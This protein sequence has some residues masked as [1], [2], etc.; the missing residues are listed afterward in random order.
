MHAVS[1]QQESIIYANLAPFAGIRTEAAG[2]AAGT[3]HQAQGRQACDAYSIA[4]LYKQQNL[5]FGFA[6]TNLKLVLV[7]YGS[8]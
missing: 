3:R 5:M 2:S 4:S 7:A 6:H 8:S 1:G